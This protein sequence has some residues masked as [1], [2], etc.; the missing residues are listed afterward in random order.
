[1]ATTGVVSVALLRGNRPESLLE[2]G[3]SLLE[4]GGRI[5]KNNSAKTIHTIKAAFLNHKNGEGDATN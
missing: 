4:E 5:N 3:G 1:M 2:E